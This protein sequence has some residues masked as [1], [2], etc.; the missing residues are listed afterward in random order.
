MY[1]EISNANIV[2]NCLF[3]T[4]VSRLPK[5]IAKLQ[6]FRFSESEK[7]IYVILFQ[8]VFRISRYLRIRVSYSSR[9]SKN[10][11]KEN[12]KPEIL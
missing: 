2:W 10:V 1:V 4:C 7:L 6:E 8:P 12:P 9:N 5:K 11:P 3:Y